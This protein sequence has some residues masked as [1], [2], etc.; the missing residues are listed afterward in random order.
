MTSGLRCYCCGTAIEG[1]FYLVSLTPEG[2]DRVFILATRCVKRVED[3]ALVLK[4]NVYKR[5]KL[6]EKR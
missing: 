6:K 5:M 4:I 1:N 3:A 2:V